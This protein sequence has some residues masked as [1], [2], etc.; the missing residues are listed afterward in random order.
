MTNTSY[1][2]FSVSILWMVRGGR[3]ATNPIE[4]KKIQVCSLC[5]FFSRFPL[6]ITS[7]NQLSFPLG[8][9]RWLLTSYLGLWG[10]IGGFTEDFRPH[11]NEMYL[12]VIP[13]HTLWDIVDIRL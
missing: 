9:S 8:N 1:W 4:K 5:Y 7:W 12:L 10:R 11:Q 6:S 13:L 2:G 3:R